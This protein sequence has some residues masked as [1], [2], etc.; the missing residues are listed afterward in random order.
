MSAIEN[1]KPNSTPQLRETKTITN[2]LDFSQFFNSEML[3]SFNLNALSD[4]APPRQSQSNG[5]LEE[6]RTPGDFKS[7]NGV[8]EDKLH[9][10]SATDDRDLR[11]NDKDNVD[12]DDHYRSQNSTEETDNVNLQSKDQSSK[13]VQEQPSPSKLASAQPTEANS[14]PNAEP[15]KLNT[16][17]VS[18]V[19]PANNPEAIKEGAVTERSDE[20]PLSVDDL[21]TAPTESANANLQI[22]G[23][24]HPTQEVSILAS[25]S[26]V[27]GNTPAIKD[28]TAAT[29]LSQSKNTKELNQASV[30]IKGSNQR[31]PAITKTPN[32]VPSEEGT[33][34]NINNNEGTLVGATS[35]TQ[36]NII[37]QK[38]ELNQVPTIN[39]PS[40]KVMLS[41]GKSLPLELNPTKPVTPQTQVQNITSTANKPPLEARLDVS[42]STQ[43]QTE[44]EQPI[45]RTSTNANIQTKN[46]TPG[47]K[48]SQLDKNIIV[49]P[50]DSS[51]S[52]RT[53][54]AAGNNILQAQNS[55]QANENTALASQRNGTAQTFNLTQ[56]Q[57]QS[58]QNNSQTSVTTPLHVGANT[59]E[60]NAN[61]NNQGAGN[62]P[63]NGASNPNNQINGPPVKD[64]I[65]FKLAETK[66]ENLAT[67]SGAAT[68]VK[69]ASLGAQ[70]TQPAVPNTPPT[71]GSNGL[72]ST[73][74]IFSAQQPNPNSKPTN[75]APATSQVS[76]QL[77]KAVQNGDN[78]IKI[79]LRP[80]ELGRVEVKL[81]IANDG[82]AK[83]LIIAERP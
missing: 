83:A 10:Q 72:Q 82:R 66:S 1:V 63:S 77:S 4:V 39:K 19:T 34:T 53:T 76:I 26:V 3:T 9:N 6:V 75:M 25:A 37:P 49:Q 54:N 22:Q 35:E 46:E 11:I 32:T 47:I 42:G 65:T 38:Q 48:L 71:I 74:P 17:S 31:A 56:Q 68:P 36:T 27:P 62:Q 13:I 40:E 80:Q 43:S 7:D 5:G 61:T 14:N 55:A 44:P 12:V 79:Q 81:E 23:T 28:T 70:S 21:I 30:P 16:G 78:K 24:E 18:E 59:G 41:D 58:N 15:I 8:K 73:N 20:L 51:I 67:R 60:N 69:A 64:A 57:V 33:Q 45:N 50:A 52:P 29:V 2:G